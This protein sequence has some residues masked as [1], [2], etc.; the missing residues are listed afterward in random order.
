MKIS[1]I[2]LLLLS[3]LLFSC[4]EVLQ[5]EAAAKSAGRGVDSILNEFKKTDS[6]LLV[7]KVNNDSL[8]GVG[9]FKK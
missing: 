8:V 2:F 4:N 6:S 9:A 5:K 3:F 7:I 1:I